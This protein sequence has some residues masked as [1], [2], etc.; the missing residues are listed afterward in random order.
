MWDEP[1]YEDGPPVVA[2]LEVEVVDHAP[3]PEVL[4]LIPHFLPIFSTARFARPAAA[5]PTPILIAVWRK[6]VGAVAGV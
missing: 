1:E 4:E 2:L 6:D 5:G 3:E